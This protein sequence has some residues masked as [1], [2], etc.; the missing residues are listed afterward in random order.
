MRPNWLHRA[1]Q[2]ASEGTVGHI[3]PRGEYHEA[4][5]SDSEPSGNL[6]RSSRKQQRTFREPS[7]FCLIQRFRH[8]SVMFCHKSFSFRVDCNKGRSSNRRKLPPPVGATPLPPEA[9]SLQCKFTTIIH[10]LPFRVY[11]YESNKHLSIVLV[12]YISLLIKK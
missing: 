2:S 1:S 7:S 6:A 10:F 8:G 9:T 3:G 4:P 5:G 12:L 11:F